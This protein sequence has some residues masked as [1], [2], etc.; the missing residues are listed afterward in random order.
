MLLPTA[1]GFCARFLFPDVLPCANGYDLFMSLARLET[2]HPSFPI[3]I[4]VCMVPPNVGTQSILTCHTPGTL[5][6][7]LIDYI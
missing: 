5:E 7:G 3:T 4:E 1:V 6:A 2:V